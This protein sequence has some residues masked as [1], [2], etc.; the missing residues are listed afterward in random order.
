MLHG[1]GSFGSQNLSYKFPR[2][3][4]V[5]GRNGRMRRK[6]T[7]VP[8]GVQVLLFNRQQGT[9]RQPVLDERQG[10]QGRVALVHVIACDMAVAQL[11]KDGHTS[12]AEHHFL[13][14]TIVR[15]TTV[16]IVSQRLVKRAVLWKGCV[17]QVDG[18]NVTL[19]TLNHEPPG[20]Y[21]HLASLNGH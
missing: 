11:G 12:H 14:E 7:L 3:L 2:K 8:N 5:A 18:N 10:E 21:F 6:H 4:I 13:T 9:S 16:Q 19:N 17:E 1:I 20:S 15:I